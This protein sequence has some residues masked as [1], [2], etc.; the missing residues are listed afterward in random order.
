MSNFLKFKVMKIRTIIL[1]LCVAA[2]VNTIYAQSKSPRFTP[3]EYKNDIRISVS[4]GSTM[5]MTNVFGT[6]L[7]DAIL[8]SKRSNEKVW[9]VFGV[10]Y[11]Y[12][13][14]RFKVGGD[15][16][17]AHVSSELAYSGQK[18]PSVKEK[19]LNFLVLPTAEFSYFRRG[20]VELYGTASAG[21]NFKRH[22]ESALTE[23]GRKLAKTKSDF[24]TAFAYQVNPIAL[25]VGNDRIG[26]FVEAGFGT[27]GFVTAGLSMGF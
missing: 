7:A 5:T 14:Q 9:G 8:G 15:F 23:E 19:E 21:A 12:N 16:G 2:S 18:K 11:R 25:R 1:S 17:F 4:D 20:V 6:G 26:G 24:S 10:G 3:S 22:S 27:K 13:I